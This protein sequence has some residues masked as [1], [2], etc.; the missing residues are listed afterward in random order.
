MGR[1]GIISGTVSLL[2]ESLADNPTERRIDT[3]FGQAQVFLTER[4]AFIPRHGTDPDHHILPHGINHAANFS[5]LQALDVTEVIAV[6]STGSLKKSL[7]P[8]MLVVP[9]DFIM[10]YP[11]P[12]VFSDK[13]IHMVPELSEKIRQRWLQAAQDCH[14]DVVDGGVYWQTPGPRFETKAEI[15]LMSQTADLVGMTMASEAIIARELD[16]SYASLC[17]VDNFAHGLVDQPLSL[18]DILRHARRNAEAAVKIIKRYLE[19]IENP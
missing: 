15:R 4:T 9:D 18:D 14:I 13:A 11:G 10:L 1:L 3:A 16:M 5:A 8:G 6:N 7:P 12:T 2:A 17:S 19:R